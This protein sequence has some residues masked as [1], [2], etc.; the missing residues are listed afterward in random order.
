MN[1]KKAKRIRK[2]VYGDMADV[3]QYKR[4]TKTGQCVVPGLRH[5]YQMAKKD[6]ILPK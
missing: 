3:R 1:G 2:A 6:I 5:T 4:I